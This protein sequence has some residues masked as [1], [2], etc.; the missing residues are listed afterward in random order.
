MKIFN[1]ALQQKKL[2]Q[3]TPQSFSMLKTI[4]SPDDPYQRDCDAITLET[5]YPLSVKNQKTLLI[6]I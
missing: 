4:I 5:D 3:D 6:L 2:S 1:F